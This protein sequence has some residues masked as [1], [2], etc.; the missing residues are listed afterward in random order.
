MAGSPIGSARPSGCTASELGLAVVVL[1]TPI[2]FRLIDDLYRGIYP[3]LEGSPQVLALV[4]VVMAVLALAPATVLMGAT[5]PTLTRHFAHDVTLTGAFSR[6]YAANTIGAIAGTV[7]AGFV[8]IEWLGLSGALAVGAGCSAAAGLA[9]LWLG[10]GSGGLATAELTDP[11]PSAPITEAASPR[12]TFIR[13]APRLALAVAFISGLT[14]LGYQV[15]WT[16][17]LASGT[18]NTTY[19]FSTILATFL[20]GIAIGAVLFA[21]LRRYLGD[22][23]RLLAASQILAAMLAIAGLVLIIVAPHEPTVGKPIETITRLIGTAITVVL[24][25]TIV[26]GI[27]FPASSALLTDDD[28]HA[29]RGAGRLLAVNT[30][31]AI[32][33]SLVVPFLLIPLMGSP[34]LVAGLA[35]VNATLGIVLGWRLVAGPA[36]RLIAS[37]GLVVALVIAVTVVRPG[38][39]VQPN[40]AYIASV[41]GRLFDSTEDE[42][43]SVQSGQKTFTPELWVAGTSM[44]LLTVDAKLMPILPLIARPA[45]T[46]ALVVAFGMGSAFRAALIAGLRTDVVELVPSVPRMFGYYYPDAAAVLADPNGRVIVTDGRNHLEL[47]NDRFDIILTDPPPPI[48]SSGAAVISSKE[49]Y[50][51]GRDHLT[52]GGIMMQWVPYGGPADDFLD[53]I[54]TFAS[55]FPEVT[56]VK[57]AGGYGIYMLGS[58]Q[59]VAFDPAN[60]RAVLARPGVLADISSAYDSPEK[61]VEGWV[62]VIARQTWLTGDAVRQTAGP[63]PLIT[64]DRPRPEYFLLRRWFAGGSP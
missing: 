41:G 51:A 5:L 7:V 2:S 19:V 13:P 27:A 24:P 32:I 10:R 52:E 56:L 62:R 6:L 31:G 21:T 35:A 29:G 3:S 57:G 11:P 58:S 4:R 22:P 40:E 47:T 43:A 1:V 55:V 34:V 53:H 9:A 64:D 46:R 20:V 16:R 63:G 14:S 38:V 17:L 61:T 18:G 8:L 30:V 54:R 60:I 49:Y 48:E 45:S 15:A 33:G 50:E 39:L 42:I 12:D 28:A 25:V 36:G 23:I 26:L 44:T 37:T 59:P